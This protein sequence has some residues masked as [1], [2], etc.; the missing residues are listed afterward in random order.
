MPKCLFNQPLSF[1]RSN[2]GKFKCVREAKIFFYK[3]INLK[4]RI[5]SILNTHLKVNFMCFGILSFKC[6]RRNT[7]SVYVYYDVYIC[8]I[9]VYDVYD[10][11]LK[12]YAEG[13]AMNYELCPQYMS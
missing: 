6:I 10:S 12:I 11:I 7:G 1:E 9:M 5:Y 4:T 3:I 2:I 13:S 8:I